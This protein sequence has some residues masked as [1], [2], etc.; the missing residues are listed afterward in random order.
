MSAF[1]YF[2]FFIYILQFDSFS[3][4]NPFAFAFDGWTDA[5]LNL[6]QVPYHSHTL[7]LF[8]PTGEE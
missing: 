1:S 8:S 7:S 6:G 5:D 4:L 3:F 2:S